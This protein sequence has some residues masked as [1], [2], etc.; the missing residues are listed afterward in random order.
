MTSDASTTGTTTVHTLDLR[1]ADGA[2]SVW[3]D[4][5]VR[6]ARHPSEDAEHFA[7]RLLAFALSWSPDLKVRDGVCRGHEP[8]LWED[9]P[10][11]GRMRLWV[12]V[13]RPDV[14]RLRHATSRADEVAL[15]AC[16]ADETV[17]AALR[18]KSFRGR[19]APRVFLLPRQLVAAAAARLS[20]RLEWYVQRDGDDLMLAFADSTPLEGVIVE[21]K[22]NAG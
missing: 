18:S 11:G 5:L 19:R 20:R 15:Y 13:G 22:L 7:T 3:R 21:V 6:I 9:S 2:R 14:E 8:A 12:D 10:H 4:V 1:L 17:L 16:P